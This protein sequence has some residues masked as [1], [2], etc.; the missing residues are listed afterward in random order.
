MSGFLF[1][2]VTVFLASLGGRDQ[3]LVAR[4]TGV[5]GRRPAL[6]A[7]GLAIGCAT[8]A[9]MAWGGNYIAAM[10]P[11]AGKTMLVAFALLLAAME[12]LW[13]IVPDAEREPTRS[14]G[15]IAIVLFARQSGDAARFA[16]FGFAALYA[17]PWLAGI[18]GALGGGAALALAWLLADELAGWPPL[19]T[20]RM[21]AG[22]AAGAAG[23]VIAL[24]ARG[25]IV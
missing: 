21:A 25:L 19:R 3:L 18:G 8:A 1:A 24:T 17:D 6:L 23:V 2:L 12:L 20:I 9:I 5:L 4:F 16:I 13:P 22:V 7:I 10:L 14:L 15:A 11:P